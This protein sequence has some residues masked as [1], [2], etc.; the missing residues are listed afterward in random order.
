MSPPA[1]QWGNRLLI[2]PWITASSEELYTRTMRELS[3]FGSSLNSG[4]L[5]S[6]EEIFLFILFSYLLKLVHFEYNMFSPLLCHPP[7]P[8][9]RKPT[10]LVT[11]RRNTICID[12]CYAPAR[13][14]LSKS[15]Q[16]GDVSPTLSVSHCSDCCRFQPVRPSAGPDRRQNCV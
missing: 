9:S 8:A 16:I 2:V 14:C 1:L 12:H 13:T 3:G 4:W 6:Q 5:Q 11:F 15:P 7:E 10:R